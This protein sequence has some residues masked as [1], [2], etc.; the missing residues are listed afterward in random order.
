MG[1]LFQTVQRS[2]YAVDHMFV[3]RKDNTGRFLKIDLLVKM[4]VKKAVYTMS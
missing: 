3:A 1:T 4:V 2:V